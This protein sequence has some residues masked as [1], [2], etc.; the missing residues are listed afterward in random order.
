MTERAHEV[1]ELLHAWEA[2][3]AHALD[4]LLPLV[5]EE[6]RRRAAVAMRSERAGH[7]LQPTALVHEAYLR[8]VDQRR[9]HW[10]SR[11]HFCAVAAEMMRRVLVD[12]A[13]ARRAAKR[14][15]GWA[16]VT[17][18]DAVA[19]TE[20]GD[21]DVLVLDAA[22]ERLATL[23]ER[24]CRIAVLRFFGGLTLADTAAALGIS[25]ATAERDW[26][27]ARAWLFDALNRGPA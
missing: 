25:H 17:L 27:F 10:R 22:L 19:F 14:S 20:P 21:L 12:R 2:G 26:R 23:D 7:T 18:D 1:T 4:R 9:V 11:A 5:Y 3:D 8:L 15:G 16:R 13:R 24:K 6:L